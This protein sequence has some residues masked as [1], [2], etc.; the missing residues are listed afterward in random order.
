MR[1]FN[2][3]D[4]ILTCS[5]SLAFEK[6]YFQG[7][8]EK[9]WEAMNQAGEAIGDHLLRDMRELR[10][11]PHHPRI[12][13]LVGK[14]HNGGDA[15]LAAK[16]L[17]KTIPTARAVI[18]GIVPWDQCRP[19][20]QRAYR[21]LIELVGKRVEEVENLKSLS[22]IKKLELVYDRLI[23]RSGF[24]ASIDGIM[25]MGAKLPI[26]AP[27]SGLFS[28]IN[29]SDC[30]AVRAAVDLPSGL[31]EDSGK[32]VLRADFTYATGVA[33][34]PVIES[35]NLH[36]TGRLRY[37]DLGF[38]DEHSQDFENHKKRVLRNRSL[39]K[40]RNLRSASSDKRSN[41]HLFLLA[42]SRN[43]AGAA[44]M[45]A[46][47]ALKAGIGLLTVGIPESL[48]SSFAAQRPEAMWVPL[49]ETPKGGLALEG[50]GKIKSFLGSVDAFA[51]GPGLGKE[52]ETHALIRETLKFFRGPAVLDADALQISI[53]S[54]L[55]PTKGLILTPHAGEFKRIA[56][57]K[58]PAE[59][60]LESKCV[61]VLKGPHT[62]IYFDEICYNCLGGSSVLARGGSGDL[63]TG[64]LGALLAKYPANP[65]D[66][67][68]LGVQWHGR[69][70]EVLARQ[71]GQ[72]AVYAT[73]LLNYLSFAMRN[74]I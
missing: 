52:A 65:L 30:I 66:S 10:T 34:T 72:E 24:S 47:A 27:L 12:L 2:T 29:Q 13:V 45:S 19:L 61:L 59:Y 40:L 7:Q 57:S 68:L 31:T 36:W 54:N 41:G 67:S 1:E 56:N 49:P 5:E 3:N 9:E 42:G 70:G 25:G 51:T 74:D 32:E 23:E 17:M 39:G 35:R 48:H 26:R 60:S 20:C 14:G 33:K 43:L 21:D 37:I 4:P 71:H 8:E 69:A 55:E 73:D 64:M 63:L 11:I 16:R 46:Q 50:L 38:F 15:L 62:Q 44:M 58:S 18:W 6:K 22:E 28:M 53:L